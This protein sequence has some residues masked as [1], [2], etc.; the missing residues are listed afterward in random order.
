MIKKLV[1]MACALLL[2]AEAFA[3]KSYTL[4]SPN[5]KLEV[6]ISAEPNLSYSVKCNGDEVLAPSQIGLKIYEGATIGEK[7]AVKKVNRT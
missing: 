7:I 3:V 4:L 1:V 2:S 6:T 5:G